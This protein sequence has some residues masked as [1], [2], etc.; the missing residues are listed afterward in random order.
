M[1]TLKTLVIKIFLFGI[2]F[3]LGSCEQIQTDNKAVIELKEKINRL[4]NT[5]ADLEAQLGRADRPDNII[6][7]RMARKI[8]NEYN[9]RAKLIDEVE[10]TDGEG[11]P[12]KAT[13][14]LFY[15]VDELRNYLSYIQK[16]SEEAGIKPSGYRFYFAKYP[17][18]YEPRKLY[19][20][21]QTIFIAP[22]L[23][24]EDN[25]GNTTHLSYLFNT[26]KKVILLDELLEKGNRQN[27]QKASFFSIL[28][29]QEIGEVSTIANELGASPP[30][31]K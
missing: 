2:L 31:F 11:K 3:S 19:S 18:E 1:K 29:S 10:Q 15:P 27:T 20:K 22:T 9:Q 21:R 5:I 28:N 24:K 16:I 8:F 14:S 12:F 7:S 30:D 25:Q 4:E 6:S 13:R 17:D 23:S 26:D